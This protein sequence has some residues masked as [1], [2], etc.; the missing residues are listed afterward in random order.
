MRF[1]FRTLLLAGAAA[2]T[3]SAAA[4]AQTF[5]NGSPSP[6]QGTYKVIWNDSNISSG[7]PIPVAVVSGG[8][9]GSGGTSGPY[10][11]GQYNST[12]P[13]FASG[14]AGYLSLDSNGRVILSPGASVTIS[15]FPSSQAVTNAG[16][17]AVQNT[18]PL[19][20]GTNLL[21]KVGIDQTTPGTTNGVA[22]NSS[23]LPAGA[24]TAANQSSE[25]AALGGT[26]D[27]AY[28]GSGTASLVAALKG[29]YNLLD[30][31]PAAVDKSY[32]PATTASNAVAA[33]AK[34]SAIYVYNQNT[35]SVTINFNTTATASAGQ[36]GNIVIPAGG[37]WRNPPGMVPKGAMSIIAGTSGG[38]VTIQE[39]TLP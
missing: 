31:V 38:V 22:V 29:V 19:P 7:N 3:M 17:F 1:R 10:Y 6:I 28:A 25:I 34:R 8:G 20:A 32:G 39:G 24:A 9:G 11:V 5:V 35:F 14:T 16:T 27:T 21:G 2:F 15:N 13:T 23:A 18:A 33:N 12:L 30:Q 26:G 36:A 4:Q 37:D